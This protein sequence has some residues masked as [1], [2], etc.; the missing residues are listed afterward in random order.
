MDEP[1]LRGQAALDAAREHLKAL[2]GLL[3]T[4]ERLF[5]AGMDAGA[6]LDTS[7]QRPVP[8]NWR[9]KGVGVDPTQLL[10]PVVRAE[11]DFRTWDGSSWPVS[12]KAFWPL[13]YLRATMPDLAD[14]AD[15]SARYLTGAPGMLPANDEEVAEL[16]AGH[17]HAVEVN[18]Y[19][20]RLCKVLVPLIAATDPAHQDL[21]NPVVI[22]SKSLRGDEV[23][24]GLSWTD[25][26]RF[27]TEEFTEFAARRVSGPRIVWTAQAG[28]A[29]GSWLGMPTFVVSRRS[30]SPVVR[31]VSRVPGGPSGAVSYPDAAAAYAA[32]SAMLQRFIST[33][34][35]ALA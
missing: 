27:D 28:K 24:P 4:V 16:V 18:A 21:R 6:V 23:V 11:L 33:A 3:V 7:S 19:L 29:V 14:D 17:A 35:S 10:T 1:V 30:G 25:L 8:E 32:A 26:V 34:R 2:D 31:M 22:R 15:K 12:V 20:T 5:H 9:K 13:A